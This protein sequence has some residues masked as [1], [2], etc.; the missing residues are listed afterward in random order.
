[1]HDIG[2]VLSGAKLKKVHT[3]KLP[4]LRSL[5][6]LLASP[7]VGALVGS[8]RII[9]RQGQWSAYVALGSGL[10]STDTVA[11]G[12]LEKGAGSTNSSVK[13]SIS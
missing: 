7:W 3:V 1:M 12:R 8:A 6:P 5:G 11:L 2:H 4:K 9:S 13:S 10:A